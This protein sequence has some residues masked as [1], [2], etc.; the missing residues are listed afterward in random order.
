MV[1]GNCGAST[2]TYLQSSLNIVYRE[3]LVSACGDN[4][5]VLVQ[6]TS[7]GNLLET[8]VTNTYKSNGYSGNIIAASARTDACPVGC[9]FCSLKPSREDDFYAGRNLTVAEIYCQIENALREIWQLPYHYNKNAPLK[10][11]F[12]KG[13]EFMLNSCI[14]E[15]IE[16]IV[17]DLHAPVK[18]STTFPNFEGFEDNFAAL[19]D[20]VREYPSMIRLQYSII[21]TDAEQRA[22]IVGKN[23]RLYGFQE[24]AEMC[25]MFVLTGGREP[26]ITFTIGHDSIVDVNEF[27]KYFSPEYAAVRLRPIIPNGT[28]AEYCFSSLEE[29]RNRLLQIA[30]E[31][32]DF[33]VVP[34][35][36]NSQ[37]ANHVTAGYFI[38]KVLAGGIS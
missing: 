8:I 13:S 5:L 36:I 11:V 26:T 12:T 2:Y 9:K 17:N 1:V 25:R 19:L 30:N 7:Q 28:N 27:R 16:F 3:H 20:C 34:H 38:R 6:Q 15:A 21:S 4:F 22:E 23:V 35:K 24:I 32:H 29:A 14:G 18:V 31:F 33:F 10:V 37:S